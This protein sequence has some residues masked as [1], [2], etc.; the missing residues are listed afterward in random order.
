MLDSNETAIKECSDQQTY[1]ENYETPYLLNSG[2]PHKCNGGR[3]RRSSLHF[4]RQFGSVF[5]ADLLSDLRYFLPFRNILYLFNYRGFSRIMSKSVFTMLLW[6]SCANIH[7]SV[8]GLH[9][10]AS[11]MPLSQWRVGLLQT[12]TSCTVIYCAVQAIETVITGIP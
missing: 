2:Q 4:C 7:T 9:L 10:L 5:F 8:C 12:A 6:S 1:K 3:T 11:S